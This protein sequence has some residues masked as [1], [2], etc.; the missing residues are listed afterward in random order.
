M[1]QDKTLTCAECGA[2]FAFS[3]ADQELHQKRG[4][5]SEPKR[6]PECREARRRH[7]RRG[8]RGGSGG[9][10]GE[11]PA[12]ERVTFETTCDACGGTAELTFEPREDRPVYCKDCFGKMRGSRS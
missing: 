11:T 9:A 8:G 2:T 6:C 7:G 12:A 3:A 4:Y 5:T 1:F 10:A